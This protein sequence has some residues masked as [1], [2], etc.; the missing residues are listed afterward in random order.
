MAPLLN[1]ADNMLIPRN[2]FDGPYLER[3]SSQIKVLHRP[4]INVGAINFGWLNTANSS[5]AL[6]KYFVDQPAF[7]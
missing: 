6:V 5:T 3:I 7:I 1:N 2:R 4:A